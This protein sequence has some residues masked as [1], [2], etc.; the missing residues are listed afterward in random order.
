MSDL[1]RIGVA[2][3][4]ELLDKFDS[5][6]EKR[7]YTNRS[8]AFRDLIRADLVN[9]VARAGATRVIGTLTLVYNHHARLL[10]D[11][12]TNLQHEAHHL[13]ISTTH[14]HL[15]HDN[16]VEVILLRGK[17]NEIHTFADAII[18]TK[19]IKHGKLVVAAA[20]AALP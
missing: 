5:L 6:M 12:L 8:E 18:A 20:D 7:G 4:G 15:D 2:L 9:E 3:S 14:A 13:I 19:G 17:S 11:K 1:R 16:C 10:S